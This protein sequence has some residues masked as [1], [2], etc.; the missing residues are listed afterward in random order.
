MS[1][2]VLTSLLQ[3]IILTPSKV[4]VF[5][6]VFAAVENKKFSDPVVCEN[7]SKP[8]WIKWKIQGHQP[9]S[10]PGKMTCTTYGLFFHSGVNNEE[11]SQHC[12]KFLVGT[13]CLHPL[14]PFLFCLSLSISSSLLPSFHH[15]TDSGLIFY[16]TKR[17]SLGMNSHLY[18]SVDPLRTPG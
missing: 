10:L 14:S 1:R 6:N 7:C 3:G 9:G 5:F 13:I 18:V 8:H 15:F 11:R 4:L 16:V 2:N 12:K 17:G